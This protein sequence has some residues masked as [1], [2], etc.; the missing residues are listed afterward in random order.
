MI[1]SQ[2]MMWRNGVLMTNQGSRL[3]MSP[4]FF[5]FPAGVIILFSA[6]MFYLQEGK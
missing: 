4:F 2:G 6:E 1:T 3:K 5:L